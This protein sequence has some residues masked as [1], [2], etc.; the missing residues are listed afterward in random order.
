M[1]NIN[2]PYIPNDKSGNELDNQVIKLL[3]NYYQKIVSMRFGKVIPEVVKYHI[4]TFLEQIRAKNIFIDFEKGNLVIV[5]STA[6][7]ANGI[8]KLSSSDFLSKYWNFKIGGIELF[9]VRKQTNETDKNFFYHQEETANE[10][11][12]QICKQAKEYGY[13]F[14]SANLP[15][16]S[17]VEIRALE[18]AGFYYAEGF[19][20]M[21]TLSQDFAYRPEDLLGTGLDSITKAEECDVEDIRKMYRDVFSLSGFPS[22][23][24]TD[25]FFNKGMA[26]D[27]Y[28]NRFEE[29]I[30]SKNE[31]PYV[32]IGKIRG[33][34][35]GAIIVDIDIDLK[36]KTGVITNPQ[37]G[38]GLIVS[39]FYKRIGIG[40][41]LICRRQKHYGEQGVEYI[42]F[43]ANIGNVPMIQNL[44]NHGLKPCG[45]LITLHKRLYN[46]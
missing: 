42:C 33:R 41:A 46:E 21:A 9:T 6:E 44:S 15:S 18:K 28:T 8:I 30:K 45:A 38:M 12:K 2:F 25:N 39:P 22:R 1:F 36:N 17:V 32:L 24:V 34:I 31:F 11:A 26:Q 14:L 23:F 37:S 29:V 10:L 40:S 4:D 16:T 43:G 5:Q 3:Q 19:L 35:V 20:N 7:Q 27:L 13:T